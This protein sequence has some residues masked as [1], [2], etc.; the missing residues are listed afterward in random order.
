LRSEDRTKFEE[1]NLVVIEE[2][3]CGSCLFRGMS[4]QSS[5]NL[6][7]QDVRTTTVE[8]I[9]ANRH[10][11]EE[12]I[13][14]SFEDYLGKMMKNTTF[15]GEQEIL[16]FCSYSGCPATIFNYDGTEVFT[17][18]ICYMCKLTPHVT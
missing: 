13:E 10:F 6:T 9:R 8:F 3:G 15:G 12:F 17:W 18:C 1:K 5:N 16:A 7:H 11:F 2:L 4:R 14:G